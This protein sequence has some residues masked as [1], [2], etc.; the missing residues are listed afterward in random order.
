[1]EEQDTME[2]PETPETPETSET[3]EEQEMQDPQDTAELSSDMAE[4]KPVQ[5]E[6]RP[7]SVY[8][9]LVAIASTHGKL[10]R[11]NGR[12]AD[13]VK[14]D[15]TSHSAF[16]GNLFIIHFCRLAHPVLETATLKVDMTGLPWLTEEEQKIDPARLFA[17]HYLSRPN[18][19][20]RFME[21]NFPAKDVDEMTDDE[22]A[23]G[24]PRSEARVKLEAW[25]LCASLDGTLENVVTSS[26]TWREG[27]WWWSPAP[28]GQDGTQLVVKTYWWRIRDDR[29]PALVTTPSGERMVSWGDASIS[30]SQNVPD[31]YARAVQVAYA[32][33][34]AS[35]SLAQEALK[36]EMRAKCYDID[37]LVC[38]VNRLVEY[39]DTG[40]M[41]QACGEVKG[42]QTKVN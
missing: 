16:V 37:P 7:K 33:V 11:T 19:T 2:T 22:I 1:M 32:L 24:E 35:R 30:V 27:N 5:R 15:L 29:I 41:R 4:P 10:Y 8:E 13:M 34:R 42:K 20:E 36:L 3:L 18:G 17:S 31:S 21:S 12:H 38:E 14:F 28:A 26:P 6:M 40:R 9:G 23:Q 39:V 25:I